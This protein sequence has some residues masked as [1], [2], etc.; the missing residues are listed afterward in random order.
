MRTLL[1]MKD[2]ER[3]WRK[4]YPER[5]RSQLLP[6]STPLLRKLRCSTGRACA[7]TKLQYGSIGRSEKDLCYPIRSTK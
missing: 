5:G 6:L 3:D 2:D 1:L 7:S 4:E